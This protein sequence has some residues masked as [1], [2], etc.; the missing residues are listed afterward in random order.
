MVDSSRS[1][2]SVSVGVV[3]R[4]APNKACR[5]LKFYYS[6]SIIRRYCSYRVLEVL[7]EEEG[8][9]R[10]GSWRVYFVGVSNAVGGFYLSD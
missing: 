7:V 10:V 1:L 5:S 9:F 8:G 3:G 2:S 4:S 6:R